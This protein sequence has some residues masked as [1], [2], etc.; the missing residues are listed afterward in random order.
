MTMSLATNTPQTT[1]LVMVETDVMDA[2]GE[3]DGMG[4]MDGMAKTAN[5]VLENTDT[6]PV[7]PLDLEDQEGVKVLLGKR[8]QLVLP[9]K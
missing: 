7:D 5:A 6:D 4:V 1:V 9:V 8:V 3:M 2:M